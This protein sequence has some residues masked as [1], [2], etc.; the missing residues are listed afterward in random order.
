MQNIPSRLVFRSFSA[1]DWNQ[2]EQI[3]LS[4][5]IPL[6]V[7]NLKSLKTLCEDDCYIEP[8][9]KAELQKILNVVN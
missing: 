8:L 9:I 2:S 1:N 4:S 5:Q 6:V 3:I 7:S